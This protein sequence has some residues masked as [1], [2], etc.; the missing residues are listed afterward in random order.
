ML[1]VGLINVSGPLD[2][3]QAAEYQLVVV[4]TDSAQSPEDVL[5]VS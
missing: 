1:Q 5:Q 2:R 4:A 3:E